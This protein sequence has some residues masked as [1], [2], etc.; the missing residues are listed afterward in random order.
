MFWFPEQMR[1][2]TYSYILDTYIMSLCMYENYSNG[3]CNRAY[4]RIYLF[5]FDQ[6]A[7]FILSD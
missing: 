6:F 2:L 5:P 7:F 1:K 4:N 3:A